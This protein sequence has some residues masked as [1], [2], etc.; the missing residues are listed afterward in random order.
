VSTVGLSDQFLGRR[1]HQLAFPK[2]VLRP[3]SDHSGQ[4]ASRKEAM[5][6]SR[7]DKITLDSAA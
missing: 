6:N 4:P 5:V 7:Q 1:L 2:L 3:P